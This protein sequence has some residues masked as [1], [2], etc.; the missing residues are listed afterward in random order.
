MLHLFKDSK[1]ASLKISLG[2]LLTIQVFSQIL[3]GSVNMTFSILF[4]DWL[5][6]MEMS[7]TVISWTY[8]VHN[9]IWYM[10]TSVSGPLAQRFGWRAAS[11]PPAFITAAV[12][13]IFPY[14]T[15]QITFFFLYSV[16]LG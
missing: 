4:G 3:S 15:S 14:V 7:T 10:V 1:E 5:K 2:T 8:N 9:F 16:V 13:A 11:L 12:F 6:S